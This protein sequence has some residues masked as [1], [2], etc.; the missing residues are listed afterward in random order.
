MKKLIMLM[1]CMILLVS[2][3]SAFDFDNRL[4]YEDKDMKVKIKN[5]FGLGE[6]LV[7]AEL[8]SHKS[9]N[10]IL[11]VPTGKPVV[12]YYD[13]NSK[14]IRKNGLGEVIFTNMETGEVENKAY[15][16]VYW[17]EID[18][19]DYQR[20]L[21]GTSKN[22]TG[23]YETIKS[24]THKEG[25]WLPYN[26][27]DIPKGITR[28]GLKTE[29]G[30]KDYYDGVWIIVGK[31]VKKHATWSGNLDVGL[32]S[33]YKL[34]NLTG[35]V[36]DMRGNNH[37]VNVGATR[38]ATGIL[39]TAFNFTY[40]EDD[41]VNL[42]EDNSLNPSSI[43]VSAW[44]DVDSLPSDMTI[45]SKWD[46]SASTEDKFIVRIS[47]GGFGQAVYKLTN[48]TQIVLTDNLDVT[49][50]FHH[51]VFTSNTTSSHLYIDG[52]ARI[53]GSGGGVLVDN[54]TDPALLGALTQAPA[55]EFDGVID[56]LAIHNRSISLEEVRFLYNSGSACVYGSDNCLDENPPTVTLNSPANNLETITPAI[57]FNCSVTDDSGVSN[58][59][60]MI[61]GLINQTNET[62]INNTSYVFTKTFAVD[63]Y[64]WSCNATNNLGQSTVPTAR[65]FS[66]V[67]ILQN[68][69]TYNN[70]TTEGSSETFTLNVTVTDQVSTANLN[71]NG[72]NY[73]GTLD[74]SNYPQVIIT[75]ILSIPTVSADFNSTFNYII[76]LNNGNK[77][78]STR[79]N[80]TILNFGVDNCSTNTNTLYNFTIV[81][82]ITQSTLVGSTQNTTGD[83]NLQLYTIGRSQVLTNFSQL[84]NQ[85][86]PFA[87]CLS[88]NLSGGSSYNIDVQVQ[89]DGGSYA[90]EFYHIQNSTISS[91]SFPT[92]ITLYD[93][94]D[95]NAQEFKITYKDSSFLAV[96]N[97]L[98]QVQR[99]YI[100]EGVFKTVE[101]PKT[102]TEGETLARLQLSDVIYTF[103][104]VKNGVTLATFDNVLAVCNN[105]A[106]G[107]CEINFNSFSSHIA[108]KD[109]TT[110][111]DFAFTLDFNEDTRTISTVYSVPSSTVATVILNTTLY[112]LIGETSVCSDTVTSSSGTLTCVVPAS[113]GNVSVV[114]VLTKDGVTQAQGIITLE[115]KPAE[116]YGSNLIFLTLFLFLTLIGLGI[117]ANPMIMAIFLVIG[118]VFAIL[119]NLTGTGGVRFIGAGATVLWFII[120]IVIVL[121]KGAKRS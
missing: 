50:G 3:A 93:L 99:K 86:N 121:I 47:S 38:G 40:I 43:S 53:N 83:L 76:I 6:E 9:V 108:P 118:S 85:T 69:F 103:I 34:D 94:H 66:I 109:F 78:N 19:D 115:G 27:K 29:V 16:F 59:S 5:A 73:T 57:T 70:E 97:A 92:N 56:E 46:Q 35:S 116:I 49:S 112:D 39:N 24:G 7:S 77:G 22:G 114:T 20:V 2:T 1:F 28:I 110:L 96:A 104:I 67:S 15:E 58:V 105:V 13:F 60:L 82:E 119:L 71:Y 107:D 98:I 90:P 74:N 42:T 54:P 18:V 12:M 64:N 100:D 41:Y 88:N 25:A 72:T 68:S 31:K 61:D 84:Y 95:D 55:G 10:Q 63:S 23:I 87:V 80:Q 4:S 106:T 65:A 113:Y 62:G 102:D 32:V 30:L 51:I 45:L 17:G 33:Y 101:I 8:K 14:E 91:S 44:F 81:D 48:G 37:G 26:S 36:Y 11:Q 75:R 89:Y 79:H 21:I 111:D 120:A 52:N 117:S